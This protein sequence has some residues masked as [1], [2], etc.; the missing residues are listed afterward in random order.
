MDVVATVVGM[1]N[2]TLEYLKERL[3]KYGPDAALER[4]KP[5]APSKRR[6]IFISGDWN[7]AAVHG[8]TTL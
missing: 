3:V 4:K 8:T 5:C 6:M 2:R 1:S 7:L